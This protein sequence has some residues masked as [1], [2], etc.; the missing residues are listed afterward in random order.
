MCIE[1]DIY[2]V[3]IEVEPDRKVTAKKIVIYN[4]YGDKPFKFDVAGTSNRLDHFYWIYF[5]KSSIPVNH[6]YISEYPAYFSI[7][8]CTGN[9][10]HFWVDFFVGLYGVL[11]LTNRLDST[12]PNQLFYR[13]PLMEIP[14]DDCNYFH[15]YEDLLFSLS[16]QPQHQSYHDVV[17]NTCYQ[18]AVFGWKPW[19]TEEVTQYVINKM[20]IRK[21]MCKNGT[22]TLVQ[23]RF[24]RVLN[25]EDLQD[26]TL[27]SNFSS[28][29]IVMFED[30][31]LK[32]QI[33]T[34]YCTDILIGIHGAGLQWASF[35]KPG[36]GLIELGWHYWD[37][38]WYANSF[39]QYQGMVT[40]TLMAKK[41]I[42]NWE[43]YV[44]NV[45]RGKPLSDGQ[46]YALSRRGPS[47]SFDNHWKWADA[48]VDP[49]VFTDRL[50][51][52]ASRIF[53]RNKK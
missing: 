22:V 48:I 44:L 40:T 4:S 23:R 18:N 27:R 19:R 52:I 34:A 31:S 29:Q 11:N 2:E 17:P 43:S 46:Q 1:E 6:T 38:G 16:I 20:G 42:L 13:D 37:P 24:R 33:Q 50:L 41:V 10:Y 47:N 49:E 53:H 45:R 5:N 28:V 35:M 14:Y 32:N 25:M 8:A 51:F 26:A 15:R 3:P 12:V 21:D 36:T 9:I 30:M 39:G 7:P